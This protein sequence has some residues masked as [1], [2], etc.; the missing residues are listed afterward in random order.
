MTERKAVHV[1][2]STMEL[3]VSFM[4]KYLLL[5]ALATTS[6]FAIGPISLGVKA[7][8]PVNDSVEGSAPGSSTERWVLGPTA[9]LHLPFNLAVEF[10]ALYRHY[11]VAGQGVNQWEFPI[12]AK[13]R[14]GFPMLKP[15][16]VAGPSFN[17]V[18]DISGF[19]KNGSSAGFAVGGGI[20]ANALLIKISPELRYTRW[21]DTNISTPPMV[22]PTVAKSNQN[23]L[24]FL[25]GFT[26]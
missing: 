16:V 7:G 2:L 12:L 21:F 8:V 18:S 15:Y 20:E 11:K 25:V 3:Q 17:S 13:Y 24:E 6:A 1:R 9:E 5:F 14:F 4:K 26:F 23:Q 10:D 22:P 19:T